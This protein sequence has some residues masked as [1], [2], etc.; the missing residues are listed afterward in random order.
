M[1]KIFIALT[2]ALLLSA[3]AHPTT[4]RTDAN[5]ASAKPVQTITAEMQ[6]WPSVYEATGTVNARVAAVISAR[7]MGYIRDVTVQ[8]GDHFREGQLLVSIDPRDL[9]VSTKRAEAAR[10]TV[11]F[12]IPE[13]DSAVTAA[14]VNLELAQVTFGRMKELFDKRSVSSQEFDEAGAKLKAARAAVEMAEAR[15]GQLN[16]Q[17][18]LADQEVRSAEVARGYAEI[19]APF[20]G[21]VLAKMADPGTLATPGAPILSV[22]KDGAY[23]FD[24]SVEESRMKSIRAGQAVSIV[25]D[26]VDHP[27]DGRVSEIVPAVDAAS[28]SYTVKIDLPAVPNL[29]SGVFGRAQFSLGSR[30]AMAIPAGAVIERGQLQSVLV[31]E[32]GV[33]R[34]RLITVGQ[35][36]NEQ[37]EVL[38]GINAGDR[39]IVPVPAGLSDGDRVEV[40]Q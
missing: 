24:A 14:K 35:K 27:L 21:V 40:R 10:E 34:T 8:A 33:A 39:I 31:V 38:S 23:R 36:A 32:N 11:R 3:C 17:I 15:R 9:D 20:A 6:N 1:R 7:M 26:T 19:R 22:E 13:A 12:S 30:Q 18:T 4:E 29:R 16:A 2:G 5:P 28:R 37:V 25:L